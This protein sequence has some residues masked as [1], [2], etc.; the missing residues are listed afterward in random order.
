MKYNEVIVT[1]KTSYSYRTFS[2]LYAMFWSTWLKHV[3]KYIQYLT[4]QVF[5]CE[6]WITSLYFIYYHNGTFGLK[7]N[8]QTMWIRGHEKKAGNTFCSMNATRTVLHPCFA[9]SE[10]WIVPI[11]SW[12]RNNILCFMEEGLYHVQGA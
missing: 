10:C 2:V 12:I 6:W 7:V 1:T 9:P 5:S 11:I 3:L 8:K 4:R